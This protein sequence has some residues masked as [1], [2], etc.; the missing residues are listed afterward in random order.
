MRVLSIVGMATVLAKGSCE[1]HHSLNK[2][3][4]LPAGAGIDHCFRC[5]ELAMG[6]GV[7]VNTTSY[8]CDGDGIIIICVVDF[9]FC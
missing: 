2:S 6:V 5:F 4:V 1:S 7:L 8:S 3:T 9:K